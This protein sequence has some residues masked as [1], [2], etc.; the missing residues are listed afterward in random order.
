MK[1]LTRVAVIKED[2]KKAEELVNKYIERRMEFEQ[3]LNNDTPQP[4]NSA[5]IDLLKQ[6]IAELQQQLAD[7]EAEIAELKKPKALRM[8]FIETNGKDE[9]NIRWAYED[10]FKAIGAPASMAECLCN[11][12][13]LSYHIHFLYA[14]T[15]RS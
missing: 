5:E 9:Q 1:E 14:Q 6:Q 10:I 12:Q 13:T 3:D 8:S 7:K 4:D 15:T 11:L 2:L